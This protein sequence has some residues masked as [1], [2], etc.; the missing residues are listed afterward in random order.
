MNSANP[1]ASVH[2]TGKGA[3]RALA[4]H[5]TTLE[6]DDLPPELVRLTKLCIL[7]TLGVMIGATGLSPE[8]RIIAD[9]T[10]RQ[11]GHP[12][13]TVLG[14]GFRTTALMAG[15]ANGSFGHMLDFDDVCVIA[16]HISIATVPVALAMAEKSGNVS[17]RELITAVAAGA[18]VMSRL[19][20]SIPIPDWRITEGWFATQLLGFFAGAATAGRMLKL[21]E[22]RMEDA[23]GIA[24][25]QLSGSY[26]MALG[27]STHMRS[28][29]AG[30]SGH[31]G[32]LAAELAQAGI[33]GPKEVLEGK[34][35][36]FATYVRTRT[37]NWDTLLDRLG[38]YFPVLDHH[39]FK[40]WPACDHTRPVN[41][42]I[43]KLLEES[44]FSAE[45]VRRVTVVG[46]S[47]GTQL[48]CD[49]LESKRRPQTSIDA[50]FSI[51]FTAAAMLR[52]GTV[53]LAD[54][55][56]TGRT[57][58]ETLAMA[59]RVSYRP[60]PARSAREWNPTV[61]VALK[62][63]RNLSRMATDA[64]LSAPASE[65][66]LT[67]KFLDCVSFSAT[68]VP[69]QDAEEAARLINHLE[70]LKD[71]RPIIHKLTP[72]RT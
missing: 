71:I 20:M 70:D 8:A 57:D 63:G 22:D 25:N 5:I 41:M 69:V 55:T 11:G 6:Y 48:L 51:P 58:P 42:A 36:L 72:A 24:F 4:R 31:G 66:F 59:D 47:G 14:F 39:H 30:F 54:Y 26:Q 38:D 67:R 53:T 21:D 62:D 9:Y 56:D 23:L 50:K 43:E 12:D 32:I 60:D 40:Q 13:C 1:L 68:P 28:M 49:P 37:P 10:S 34:Y 29:Q 65:Q 52:R 3:T 17:G 46:G 15:M 19:E 7:D 2:A 16:S 27:A 35:G 61:E 18:D 44:P 64:E 45:D 33:S